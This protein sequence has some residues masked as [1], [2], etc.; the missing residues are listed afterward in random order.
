MVAVE[1][2]VPA[3]Q[4]GSTRLVVIGD[5]TLWANQW[6]ENVGANANLAAFAANWLVSQ[7]VLLS[8]IPPRPIHSYSLTMTH[9]QLRSVQ[10]ILLAG[11]PGAL[12]LIG[13]IVWW[14]RRH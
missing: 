7:N 6:I 10:L 2:S 14:R 8:D 4:R 3:L 12:L 13:L 11:F 1:K 5:S 9:A